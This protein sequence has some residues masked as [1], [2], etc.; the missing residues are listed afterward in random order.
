MEY[1]FIFGGFPEDVLVTVSGVGRVA[2][3]ARLFEDLTESPQFEPGMRILLDLTR[4]DMTTFPGVTP[5]KSGAGSRCF[6]AA[7]KD[8]R[9]PSSETIRLLGP[10]SRWRS[11]EAPA[12]WT[13]S[14]P[15]RVL[16]LRPGCSSNEH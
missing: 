5:R 2:A 7:A 14:R 16:K 13:C 12:G 3:F 1:A 8:V 4:V 9:S 6:T 11:S 15:C 10:W